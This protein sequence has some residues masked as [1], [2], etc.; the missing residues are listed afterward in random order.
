MVEFVDPLESAKKKGRMPDPDEEKQ[1]KGK[2]PRAE[3]SEARFASREDLMAAMRDVNEFGASAFEGRDKKIW[4]AKKLAAAGAVV[5]HTIK[6]PYKMLK[7]VREKQRAKEKKRAEYERDSGVV[8]GKTSA[9][10]MHGKKKNRADKLQTRR[11]KM[12][13]T[14]GMSSLPLAG[15]S[16]GVLRVRNAPKQ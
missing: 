7:G 5:N 8:H 12:E 6:M 9:K 1:R 15:F 13:N 4:E 11:R 16:D 3:P 2:K 10:F 14:G